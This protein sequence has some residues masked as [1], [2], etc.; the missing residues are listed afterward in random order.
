MPDHLGAVHGL[1]LHSSL[2]AA[3][4][5]LHCQKFSIKMVD[6]QKISA[7]INDSAIK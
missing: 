5:V 2:A 4:A 1:F 3:A 6:L 7:I